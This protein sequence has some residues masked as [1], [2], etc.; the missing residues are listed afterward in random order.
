MNNSIYYEYNN[1]DKYIKDLDI[2]QSKYTIIKIIKKNSKKISYIV[3]DITGKKFFCKV[4]LNNDVT[5][6]EIIIYKFL[7][8]H[9]N[10]YINKIL[11]IYQNQYF[12]IIISEFI[13]GCIL[14]DYLINNKNELYEIF[15]K[16]IKGVSFLHENS[17]I[18][19]DL[20]LDNI[21]IN[22]NEP[23]I[24]DFDLS[25]KIKE[26]LIT[27]L[28][29]S[30]TKFYI[31]PET[32]NNNIYSFKNDIWALGIIFFLLS[33]SPQNVLTNTYFFELYIYDNI[34]LELYKKNININMIN[35]IFSMINND[36]NLRPD[37]N[38]ISTQIELL[39]NIS[40]NEL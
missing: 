13:N 33:T 36:F 11:N 6:D 22:N 31:P 3:T 25:K 39:L 32:I 5:Q 29:V 8:E 15:N 2:F 30:G 27:S 40:N 1:I 28:K 12:L 16:I 10:K 7:K 20:K 35:I 26:G 38:L 21:M 9:S 17:I 18:H 24:I 23:I 34:L 37:I 19:A 14:D 4:K